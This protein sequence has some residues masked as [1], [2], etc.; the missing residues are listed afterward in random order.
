LQVKF[1]P[2]VTG[3]ATGQLTVKSTSSS[4]PTV[5]VNLSGTGTTVQHQVSLAWS[6]P[7]NS[8]PPVVGYRVYRATGSSTS[9][10]LLNSTLDASVSY[11]DSSVQS[12][13]SYT[14]NV[15]SVDG[16]GVESVPSSKATATVP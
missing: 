8:T 10:A 6:P 11:V 12:G 2:T 4:N 3:A 13:L 5:V 7:S 16:S 15:R 1:N 14:Y 9:Y